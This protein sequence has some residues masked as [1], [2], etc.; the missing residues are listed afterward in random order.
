ME[1]TIEVKTPYAISHMLERLAADPLHVVDIKNQQVKLPFYEE[2]KVITVSFKQKPGV[3]EVKITG[4]S[5]QKE[6]V[7]ERLDQIFLWSVDLESISDHFNSTKL[8]P[9]FDVFYGAPIVCDF[10]LYGC[11]MKTIIHQQLNMKFAHELTF[12]FVKEFGSVIDGVS[13]YPRPDRVSELTVDQLRELQFSGRKAEYIIDTSRKIASGELDLEAFR[14]QSDEDVI[15][16]LIKIRGIGKWTAEN[17]LLFGLGR[18][19]LMPAADIGIQN[20]IKRLYH[21]DAKPRSEEVIEYS[22]EWHPYCSYASLYL[23]LSVE[24]PHLLEE[25]IKN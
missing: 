11:L 6:K 5:L 2:S 3:T 10:D 22:K 16:E 1:S 14:H 20:A 17:F 21:L 19:N 18:P 25:I 23:W 15:D 9:L 24:R 13:F 4:D 7:L 8:A 12:R